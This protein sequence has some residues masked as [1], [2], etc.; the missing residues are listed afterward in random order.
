MATKKNTPEKAAKETTGKMTVT[1]E[2]ARLLEAVQ[3]GDSTVR[4]ELEGQS[5]AA[6]KTLETVNALMDALGGQSPASPG[7]TGV[8]RGDNAFLQQAIRKV[9][10]NL[11]KLAMGDLDSL[12]FDYQ[13]SDDVSAEA[14]EVI[15]G[16]NGSMAMVSEMLSGLVSTIDQVE[17]EQKA[18]D[19]EFVFDAAQ[20]PGVYRRVGE[21]INDMLHIHIDAILHMLNTIG[22]YAEGDFE[23]VLRQFPGKQVIA[24]QRMNML[25]ENLLRVIQD[26]DSLAKAAQR[27]QLDTRADTSQHGGDFRRIIEGINETLDSFAEKVFWYESMLDSIPFPISVTDND[28]NWTFINQAAEKVTG[29]RRADILGTACQSWGADICGTERCGVHMLKQGTPTSTFNQPGLDMDFQVD[30]A[31]LNDRNGKHTGHIEVVQDVTD[32]VKA[33]R[34]DERMQ[35]YQEREIEHLQQVMEKLASGDLS[36]RYTVTQAADPDEEEAARWYARLSQLVNRMAESLSDSVRTNKEEAERLA[37]AAEELRSNA[38]EMSQN[39]QNLRELATT[40]A[41]ATEEANA[42]IRNVAAGIEQVSSQTNTVASASEQVSANLNAV[43]SAVEE[44]SANMNEI[45]GA[46]EQ[47]TS[48]VNTVAT[49]IE[50]MSASLNEVAKNSSQA[51]DIANRAANT[52][53]TT[54]GIMDK[55]GKSAK[56][57]GKVVEMIKG[58]A[59]QTNL[60]ALNATI[61]AASAGEAGKGFAVVANEVKELAKQTASA[62]EDIRD[63]VEDMQDA[64]DEAVTAIR[65]IVQVISEINSISGVIAAAVEEQTSTTNEISHSLGATANGANEVARNVQHAAQGTNEVSRNVQ[66]AVLGVNDIARNITEVAQSSNMIAQNAGEAAKGMNEVA[67]GVSQVDKGAG[68]GAKGAQDTKEASEMLRQISAALTDSL[69]R[70]SV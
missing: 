13:S 57:I 44:I 42:S 39:A 5:A 56:S 43:G 37:L 60:L 61:E 41:A 68:E 46:A 49:A 59:S 17:T 33:R 21:K 12:D 15:D 22:S 66:Q 16:L 6:R 55:L 65:D 58:I 27:N 28:M 24:N 31:Y 9:G 20:F 7:G 40:A 14:R 45:A 30:A 62:T 36:A 54:A 10:E 23:P 34:R 53:N 69:S 4:A 3:A 8:S 48:N 2:L 51:A 64:T 29:K 67:A 11:N 63:Q 25:R 70:F 50:E 1:D 26:I 52:A 18:G 38:D 19:I 32:R 47:M 35:H